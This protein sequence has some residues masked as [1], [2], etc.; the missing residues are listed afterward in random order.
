MSFYDPEKDYNFILSPREISFINK[1]IRQQNNRIKKYIASTPIP[2]GKEVPV[3]D[4]YIPLHYT[5]PHYN[6]Y[7]HI[8]DIYCFKVYSPI[9]IISYNTKNNTKFCPLLRNE[10]PVRTTIK[11]I[12]HYPKYDEEGKI[13]FPF[14]VITPTAIK[15]LN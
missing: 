7:S 8:N 5:H 11:E 12:P 10:R 6:F 9:D 15:C 1:N 13:V 2:F 4:D 3:E 14:R